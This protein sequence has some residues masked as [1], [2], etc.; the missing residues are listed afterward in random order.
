MQKDRGE[1]GCGLG[2][3]LLGVN[4]FLWVWELFYCNTMLIHT[5]H[6]SLSCGAELTAKKKKNLL[7]AWLG[8]GAAGEGDVLE[9][10]HADCQGPARSIPSLALAQ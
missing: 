8:R 2:R 1:A 10:S 3:F 5:K 6:R 9:G 4:N 7:G